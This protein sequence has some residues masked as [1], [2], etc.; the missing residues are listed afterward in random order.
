MKRALPKLLILLSTA[1]AVVQLVHWPIGF[2]YFTQLS[3]LYAAAVA[4]AQLI[5]PSRRLALWKY[6]AA[7]SIAITFLVYLLVLAPLMPGGLAAAYAQDHWASLCLHILNPVLCVG[8]FLVNDAPGYPW[9]ARHAW[10]SLL[11]PLS[12]FAFMLILGRFGVRW[13]GMAAPYPFLNYLAPAGWFGWRPETMGEGT[14]GFGVAYAL[15]ALVA[16][17]LT[18]GYALVK[19]AQ[20]QAAKL[21][22][23]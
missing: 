16:A 15:L 10:L 20:R 17:V 11:F 21:E 1:Y 22:A 6:T 13:H 23:P 14:L 19:V 8:D 3:N 9:R 2:T 7:V 18:V 4:L 5:A 12:W